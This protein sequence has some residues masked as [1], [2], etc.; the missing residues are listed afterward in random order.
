VTQNKLRVFL[1]ETTG[2]TATQRKFLY[3]VLKKAELEVICLD[4]LEDNDTQILQQKILDAIEKADCSIHIVGE[5]GS[6]SPSIT[7]I[8][9]IEAKKYS[10]NRKQEFKIFIWQPNYFQTGNAKL[11]QSNFIAAIRNSILNNITISNHNSP[12]GFVED[13]YAVMNPTRSERPETRDT[14]IFFIH[15]E[16]DDEPARMIVDLLDDVV[17]TERLS[18]NQSADRDYSTFISEQT[19]RAK[20]IVVYF[21]WAGHW[22]KPFVQQL[23][24]L[25]GG[26][27]SDKPIL[28]ICEPELKDIF[29][30]DFSMPNVQLS[31]TSEELIPLEIKVRYDKLS[32]E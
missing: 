5:E 17:Q 25:T 6:E 15:N 26:A 1:S 12:V 27:S 13:L 16:L 9:L 20:M 14:E 3:N 2:D 31:L 11:E 18:M 23:W 4:K 28:I 8:Q 30:S 19:K 10:K 24:R 7:E 22:A 29:P 21:K 32:S